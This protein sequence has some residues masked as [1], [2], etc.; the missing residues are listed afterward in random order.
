M[1]VQIP[2][3]RDLT[4][5]YGKADRLSPLIRR[6][7]ANNPSP[8]TL[9]GTGTYILGTGNVAVIDPG[10]DDQNH[11]DALLDATAGETITH[12][13][14]T[15]T[16][17]DHSPGCALL[18]QRCDARTYGFGPHGG[19]IAE[20]AVEMEEGIDRAFVPDVA[21]RDGDIVQGEGWSVAGVHTPGHTSNHMCYQLQEERALFTGDHIMGWS[22]SII[23]PPDGD[24]RAYM[25]SLQLLLDRD[26]ALYWPTHGPAII[27][28]HTHVQGFI[29]HRR[30]RERQIVG[31]IGS[32]VHHIVDMVP[33]MYTDL[34]ESMYPKAA[35]SVFA[36][37]IWM[38][39][40]GDL[41]TPAA[42]AIDAEYFLPER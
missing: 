36:Q 32:G 16:H 8:F 23:V 25:D 4:F 7:I 2:Y 6:V 42:S 33:R 40:R 37:I 34:P 12:I 21:V 13:L 27:E 15:H 35:Q 24:M 9:F 38:V 1:A 28:T 30:E 22:T 14:V 10:P 29:D 26:D 39:E 41:T 5:E 17:R 18:Q 20:R 31:C 3:R 11:I 19:G